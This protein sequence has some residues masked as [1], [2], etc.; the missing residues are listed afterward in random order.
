MRIITKN[1]TL[2]IDGTPTKFHLKKLVAFSGVFMM[3][4]VAKRPEG[5]GAESLTAFFP[6]L[7]PAELRNLMISA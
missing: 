7:S 3:R 5:E 1:N 4:P 2:P 6:S